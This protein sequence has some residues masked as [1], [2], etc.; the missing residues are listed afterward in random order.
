VHDNAL[1]ALLRLRPPRSRGGIDRCP[2]VGAFVC[3]R[4]LD[5]DMLEYADCDV[6]R[7]ATIVNA[8]PIDS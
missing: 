7:E 8:G 3:W 4:T 1:P 6:A 5:E 2:I